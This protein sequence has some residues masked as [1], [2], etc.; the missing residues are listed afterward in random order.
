MGYVTNADIEDRLGS[1]TY[2]QLTDDEGTGSA[3]TDKVD[4]ARLGAEGELDSYLARRYAVPIDVT[5]HEELAGLLKSIALDI[6]E[7]RLQGRRPPVPSAVVD[8]RNA[9]VRWLQQVASGEIVLPSGSELPGN[10]A[11]GIQGE[12]IGDL[13]TFTDEEMASW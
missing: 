10:E 3:D 11:E 13:R 9:A 8:K 4:E 5:A 6:A 7:F 2:V 1:T 12:A